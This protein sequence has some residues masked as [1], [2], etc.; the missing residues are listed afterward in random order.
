MENLLD[1]ISSFNENC[2]DCG[3][4][5]DFCSHHI[6]V[7]E[8]PKVHT[9]K[10]LANPSIKM[11]KDSA[12]NC[13]ECG[14]CKTKCPKELNYQSI[15]R[16]IKQRSYK[17][18][19][20]VPTLRAQIVIDFHQIGNFHPLLN[21]KTH[22][23]S[24]DDNRKAFFPGCALIQQSPKIVER[25]YAF[26]ESQDDNIGL[27]SYCCGK[28]TISTGNTE[29]FAKRTSQL[30]QD[31]EKFNIKEIIVA[32]PNCYKTLSAL[33][34]T[35]TITFITT[36]LIRYNFPIQAANTVTKV[37][38]HDPCPMRYAINVHHD[39]REMATSFGNEVIERN[40]SGVNTLCCGAGGMMKVVNPSTSDRY[41]NE[42]VQSFDPSLPIITYCRECE[43]ILNSKG[44]ETYHIL[45]LLFA[46]K[47]MTNKAN[48]GYDRWKN[49][50]RYVKK[51]SRRIALSK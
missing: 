27:M 21:H 8:L 24:S 50:I 12:Y 38:I 43:H 14:R 4:C 46:K 23:F 42:F 41:T 10:L 25:T 17:D 32:C 2:I 19:K 45:D 18:A 35:V 39:I 22:G 11:L 48:N 30:V 13:N 29:G 47:Q 7:D 16:E 9:G 37:S 36:A 1:K 6:A 28:P 40:T 33:L 3:L 15:H 51:Q 20:R 31:V 34:P 26:L 44:F 5:T 49:R